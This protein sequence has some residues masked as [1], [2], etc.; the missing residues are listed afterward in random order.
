MEHISLIENHFDVLTI[1]AL[2]LQDGLRKGSLNSVMIVQSYLAQIRKHNHAGAH[3]NATLSMPSEDSLLLI[4]RSLD[5]ERSAGQVRG[6]LHGIPIILKDAIA[7]SP[8][9]GMETSVGSYALKDSVTLG[10]ATI[11]DAVRD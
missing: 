10:N 3:L 2:Q 4:A 8:K 1:T 9:L 11:V 7:T 6:P 5:V